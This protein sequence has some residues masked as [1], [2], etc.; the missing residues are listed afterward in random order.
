M[1]PNAFTEISNISAGTQ[2]QQSEVLNPEPAIE[3]D[4]SEVSE[5]E[6]DHVIPSTKDGAGFKLMSTRLSSVRALFSNTD[7]VISK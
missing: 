6:D 1:N 4:R 3:G 7:K 5:A 2:P